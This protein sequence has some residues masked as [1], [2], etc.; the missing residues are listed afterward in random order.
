MFNKNIRL[1]ILR[2]LRA[3]FKIGETIFSKL[4]RTVYS[5]RAM[6][7]GKLKINQRNL[8]VLNYCTT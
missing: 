4:E 5:M 2:V 1:D 7:I 6:E 3:A 8:F